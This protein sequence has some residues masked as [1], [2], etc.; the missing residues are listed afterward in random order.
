MCFECEQDF[1]ICR[2]FGALFNNECRPFWNR[3][4]VMHLQHKLIQFQLVI[5]LYLINKMGNAKIQSENG[6]HTHTNRATKGAEVANIK[7]IFLRKLK[8]CIKNMQTIH[9]CKWHTSM[10]SCKNNRQWLLLFFFFTLEKWL[11]NKFNLF[12]FFILYV[13]HRQWPNKG[14]TGD[15]MNWIFD[16]KAKIYISL[17]FHI[18]HYCCLRAAYVMFKCM[19]VVHGTRISMEIEWRTQKTACTN[20]CSDSWNQSFGTIAKN[21]ETNER[22]EMGCCSLWL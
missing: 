10:D 3:H 6:I 5:W 18:V 15:T 16:R 12:I 20:L 22:R 14:T 11:P 21:I 17:H 19:C 7:S 9:F 4:F 8:F 13:L 2:P 1:R